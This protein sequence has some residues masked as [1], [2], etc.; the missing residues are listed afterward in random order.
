MTGVASTPFPED[1]SS[2]ASDAEIVIVPWSA[3]A[4]AIPA[5]SAFE[6]GLTLSKAYVEGWVVLNWGVSCSPDATD[7]AVYEGDLETL[8]KGNWDHAPTTCSTSSGLD[9]TLF[10]GEGNRYFLVAP[11]AGA[12]EGHLG[13]GQDDALRPASAA[14]CAP[15]ESTPTCE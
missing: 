15:R 2:D 1:C 12:Y 13:H 11:V 3:K 6:G 7:Y 8:R 10:T 9:E 14:A 5:G 4:G